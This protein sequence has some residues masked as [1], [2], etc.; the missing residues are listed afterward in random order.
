MDKKQARLRRARKVRAKI[1]ERRVPRLSVHRTPRHIYAQIFGL[2]DAGVV[3]SASTLDRDVRK[4]VSYGGNVEAA[5]VVGRLIAER[6]KQAGVARVA[7]DRSGFKFHGR[8]Q[9]LANSAREH[10]LEF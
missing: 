10:G 6:A 8:I 3:V 7:F 1:I 2:N 4:E 9:A 5:K